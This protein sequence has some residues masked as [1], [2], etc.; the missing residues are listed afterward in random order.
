M[1]VEQAFGLTEHL[2]SKPEILN[3]ANITRTERIASV[4]E[5]E[6]QMQWMVKTEQLQQIVQTLQTGLAKLQKMQDTEDAFFTQ[7]KLLHGAWKVRQLPGANELMV[8]MSGGDNVENLAPIKQSSTG[9]SMLFSEQLEGCSVHFEASVPTSLV[10]Q[11]HS[12]SPSCFSYPLQWGGAVS[13]SGVHKCHEQLLEAQERLFQK[14][15]FSQLMKEAI[16]GRGPSISNVLSVREKEVQVQ[17]GQTQEQSWR[18]SL[19]EEAVEGQSKLLPAHVLMSKLYR[20]QE[21]QQQLSQLNDKHAEPDPLSH[22]VLHGID[23]LARHAAFCNAVVQLLEKIACSNNFTTVC[24]HL[25]SVP[26]CGGQRTTQSSI[27]ELVLGNRVMPVYLKAF[28][29]RIPPH[30]CSHSTSILIHSLDLLCHLFLDTL[31]QTLLQMLLVEMQALGLNVVEEHSTLTCNCKGDPSHTLL[32]Q[33]R[34]GGMHK[35]KLEIIC[36]LKTSDG[37]LQ[38][39]D[40]SQLPGKNCLEQFRCVLYMQQFGVLAQNL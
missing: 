5:R 13:G 11:P 16:Q 22:S 27:L 21:K 36:S 26:T 40:L 14:R 29:L 17:C 8:E 28:E 18:V 15:C 23:G 20:Q 3:V 31:R 25:V 9:I 38:A 4:R 7:L 32:V 1:E 10:P 35:T 24:V 33:L 37:L 6:V 2:L 19:A 12:S 30:K 34:H 39:I